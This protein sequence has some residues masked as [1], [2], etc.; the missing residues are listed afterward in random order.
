MPE[1]ND[2]GGGFSWLVNTISEKIVDNK[3]KKYN[4]CSE[5]REEYA[6]LATDILFPE[7]SYQDNIIVS[8]GSIETRLR[9]SERLIRNCATQGQSMV[10]LHLANKG[11]E[12]IVSWHNWGLVAN[13]HNKKFDAFTSFKLPEI[14]QVVHETGRVK[15]A[16]KPAG[17]YIVQIV[18]E[19]LKCQKQRPYFSNYANFNYHQI[20]ERIKVCLANGLITQ[21]T[22]DNLTSLLRMGQA[23]CAKIDA[24]FYDAQAAL[25][26]LATKN[27]NYTRGTSVLSA[28]RKGQIICLDLSA[29][30]NAMLIEL[31]VNSLTVAMNRGYRFSL[32][33]DDVALANNEI[34]KNALCQKS[35]HNNIICS[36]DLYALLSGK[37][38]MFTTITG[39]AQKTVLLSHGSHISCEKWS[40]YIGEYDKIEVTL[41]N[42]RSL[43]ESGIRGFSVKAGK[44][45]AKQRTYK[46][47]PEEIN[48]LAQGEIF[49]YDNETGSLLHTNVG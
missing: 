33:L 12:Q 45:M 27:A 49:M 16:L 13:K 43:N 5:G 42:S 36:Q 44:T 20:P 18:F 21:D 39:E 24:F 32:F 31:L 30:S 3:I 10:I 6:V 8:G 1:Q 19:L 23:E 14:W 40:K 9:L 29:S 11:L 25:N 15:Y 4:K 2:S 41:Y 46:I 47:K 37:D 35:N 34:L 48:R 28:I 22:A 7:E 38:D 17:R 26:H